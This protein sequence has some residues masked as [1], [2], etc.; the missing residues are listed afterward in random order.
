MWDPA[1][2]TSLIVAFTV[3]GLERAVVVTEDQIPLVEQMGLEPVEDFRGTFTG[4]TDAEIYRWA[5][6]RYWD[7]TSKDVIVWMGG[8]GGSIMKPGVAD[9]GIYRGA[10]FNDLSTL[11][12][13]STEYALAD[14][15]LS[16]MNPMSLVMGWHSYVKDK[17]RDHVSLTSSYGLRVEGLHT[18]P[19]LSFSS[20]VPLSPGFTFHNN[21]NVEP[22]VEVVPEKKVYIA[23]V[24]TDGLGLGAWTR[25]GRGE[26][27]YAWE[28]TMN[29]QWMAPAMLEYF[30]SQAT[31]NDFFIGG[32][33]GPGYMYPKA[34]PEDVLPGMLAEARRIMDL[35]DLNVFSIMDYSEGATVEGNAELT[36]DVVDAYYEATPDFIGYVN[37][38]APTFTFTSRSGVP[39][40][41][42]DY[43][44]APERSEAEAV[45]DLKELM[46]INDTRP[47]F[48][49]LHVRQWSDITR[50]KSI[51]DALGPEVEV[52]PLDVFL[53]MAGH[54]P[55][56]EERFLPSQP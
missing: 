9:Y 19:N 35:L 50:V 24:Q 26:I 40:M 27:P 28:V 36:E 20:Q 39:F 51:L 8:E 56:F 43:Y 4:M 52:V 6:D 5:Y 21:H 48:L 13:D 54:E 32:L 18:L 33:S 41:S 22:G 16:E 38:Y 10:F 55:T 15:L 11:P 25:P 45:A 14:Q 7:R 2:R 47:Y 23:A 44:L 42:Y 34:I 12:E 53:K 17:E 49:L 29:W 46:R 37:G 3:A 1:V 30:Y 31:P